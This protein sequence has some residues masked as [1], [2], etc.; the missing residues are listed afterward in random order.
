MPK[1]I[2][3]SQF[4]LPYAHTGSW[5]VMYFNYLKANHQ[6]DYIIC[7]EP[8]SRIDNVKYEF[9]SFSTILKLKQKFLKQP[10]LAYFDAL[11]KIVK[12]KQ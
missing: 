6:I 7:K 11:K 12:K 1:V 10:Y 4:P 2:L 3:I 8:Q 5:T 9:V